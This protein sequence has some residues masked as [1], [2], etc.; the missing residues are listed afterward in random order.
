M[1]QP[2][3]LPPTSPLAQ[4]RPARQHPLFR[5]PTSSAFSLD[6]AKNTLHNMG[7][8]GMSDEGAGTQ[9]A[10]PVA[11]PPVRPSPLPTNGNS[12]WDPIWAFNKEEM[13][14]LCR[15]YEEEIGLMYPIVNIDQVMIHGKNLY[16]FIASAL[17]TGLAKTTEPG[18]GIHDLDSCVLKMVLAVA[19][20][21]ESH[22]QSDIGNQLFESI[23][24]EADRMLHSE[25]IDVKSLPLL[26]LVVGSVTLHLVV[27]AFETP[28]LW[29][30]LR[31]FI[32]TFI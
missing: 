21:T 23:R 16:A 7:Y 10:T 22:G 24:S 15:V 2:P 1:P 26:V 31:F 30:Q 4:F 14:R 18:Q 11:S 32:L 12:S 20:I 13:L 19:T 29:N 3:S 25:A 6:V 28:L 27:F 8:Q 9:D 5:G 17:Q